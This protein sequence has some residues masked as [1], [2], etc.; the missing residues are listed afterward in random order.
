MQWIK[1]INWLEWEI[2]DT[3]CRIANLERNEPESLTKDAQLI[4]YRSKL[5][6][7]ERTLSFIKRLPD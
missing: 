5:R 4:E 3:Q 2:C 1:L 6:M 7:A